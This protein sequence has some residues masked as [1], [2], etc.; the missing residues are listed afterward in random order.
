MNKQKKQM[1]EITS[2][3]ERLTEDSLMEMDLQI[4]ELA[5][6]YTYF[7][8]QIFNSEFGDEA[9]IEMAHRILKSVLEGDNLNES[10]E[11]NLKYVERE[12]KNT[13]KIQQK[14]LH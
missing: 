10:I 3:I 8:V 9:T 13:T 4:F 5:I 11:K 6:L 1:M 2:R 12:F 14:I 7:G